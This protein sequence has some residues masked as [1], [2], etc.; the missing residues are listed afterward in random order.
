MIKNASSRKDLKTMEDERK[1][2]RHLKKNIECFRCHEKG[3]YANQCKKQLSDNNK[4]QSNG[5]AFMISSVEDEKSS[6]TSDRRQQS[7]VE[8]TQQLLRANVT[9]SA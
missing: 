2:T 6:T 5:C 3:H 9:D 7:S 8:P 1:K 4:D